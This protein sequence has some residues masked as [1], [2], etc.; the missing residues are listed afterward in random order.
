VKEDGDDGKPIVGGRLQLLDGTIYYENSGGFE[1]EVSATGRT[2]RT[3]QL[4]PRLGTPE[5]SLGDI[6]F[7]SGSFTFPI[8]ADSREVT[9]KMKN[10][11]YLRS[12]WHNAEWSANF[13]L[14]SR[15]A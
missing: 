13:V 9:I 2:T 10:S 6:V 7:Y 4:N 3:Y 1:V 12:C 8:L 11:S 15:R 14:N 5:S